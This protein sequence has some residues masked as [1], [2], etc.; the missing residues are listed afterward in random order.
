MM[1][2]SLLVLPFFFIM[3]CVG[4]Y[5]LPE[6]SLAL[7]II[8]YVFLVAVTCSS[9]IWCLADSVTNDYPFGKYL[10]L[11]FVL[12]LP[13]GIAIYL[14][15]SRGF[16][17]GSIALAKVA[18]FVAV[19]LFLSVVCGVVT[20][21]ICSIPLKNVFYQTEQPTVPSPVTTLRYRG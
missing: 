11:V 12:F 20:S 15:R 4:Y 21:H 19:M 6:G 7:E 8:G 2:I 10:P 13:L 14:Y 1:K 17:N 16:K 9:L 3:I 18:A 5:T